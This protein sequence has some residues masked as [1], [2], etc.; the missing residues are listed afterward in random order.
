MRR[1]RL[2]ELLNADQPS[3]GT[4]IHITYPG[5]VELIG[6]AGMFDYVE[7]LGRAAAEASESAGYGEKKESAKNANFRE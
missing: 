7:F 4:H 2:R 1:N 3:L 5:I 6:H